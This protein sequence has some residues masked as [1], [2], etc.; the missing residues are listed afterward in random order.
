MN[1]Y[2]ANK[3]LGQRWMT[4]W[5]GLSSSTPY[6][7]DNDVADETATY[8]RVTFGGDGS[9]QH[10]LGPAGNRRFRRRGTVT[11]ELHSPAN[12]GRKA[13][14]LLAG[15]V[16]TIFEGVR[17]GDSGGEEGVTT[18]ATSSDLPPTDGERVILV[19]STPFEYDEAR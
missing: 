15:H 4:L 13:I 11:V 7:F 12:A 2:E 10:T 19:L 18:F 17:V 5:P 14:D 9:R 1:Q 3:A 8:A 16:R 6:V